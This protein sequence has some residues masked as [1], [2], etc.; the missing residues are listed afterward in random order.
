MNEHPDDIRAT[1]YVIYVRKSTDDPQKQV[2]SIDDQI[3]E[4][5]QLAKQKDL[6]IVGTVIQ[7]NLSAKKPNRRPKF[8]QMIEAIERGDINGII[9]WHPDRLARNMMEGGQIIQLIDDGKL[10]DLKF[11]SFPF[12]NDANGKMMLGISF[13]LSKHYSDKLSADVRRGNMNA[14]KEGKSSGSYKAGYI[15]DNETGFYHPE[16]VNFAIMQK[17]WQMRLDG[18]RENKIVTDMNADGYRR[19]L[20]GKTVRQRREQPMTAPKLNVYFTDPIYYGVLEQ[21][22]QSIDLTELYEFETMVT[23]EE[24]DRVGRMKRSHGKEKVK[25]DFPFRDIVY[26]AECKEPRAI[27]A[28]RGKGKKQRRKIYYRCDTPDCKEYG[29]SVRGLVVTEAISELV[30]SINVDQID[31]AELEKALN[32]YV[33]ASQKGITVQLKDLKTK[34]TKVETELKDMTKRKIKQ[35]FT[36]DEQAAYEEETERLRKLIGGY[37]EK[38]DPLEAMKLFSTVDVEGFLNTL[39]TASQDYDEVTHD[40]KDTIAKMLVLNTYV[41]KRKVASIKLKPPFDEIILHPL[42]Q[43]GG[44]DGI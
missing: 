37:K 9:A 3:A 13:A 8:K 24:W 18:A 26:C 41:A 35:T 5:K 10:L 19:I 33:A 39:K 42:V 17:A 38:I 4:C 2:R 14:L 40:V 29:K 32:A 16:P 34:R 15:R 28:S 22:D 20:K 1:R 12:T 30:R 23:K 7:D 31:K 43:N 44:A 6:P 11:V 25:Y 27:G 21:R 36:K